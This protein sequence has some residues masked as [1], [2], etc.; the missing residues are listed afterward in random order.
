MAHNDNEDKRI[1]A[2][3]HGDQQ[4]RQRKD[5]VSRLLQLR[6]SVS[7]IQANGQS[8][9]KNI[10]PIMRFDFE[11]HLPSGH[12]ERLTEERRALLIAARKNGASRLQCEL[13]GASMNHVEAPNSYRH[14]ALTDSEIADL[15]RQLRRLFEVGEL[16][17]RHEGLEFA[18]Q[19]K[20]RA[21][22]QASKN[23]NSGVKLSLEQAALIG[24]AE[25]YKLAARLFTLSRQQ[26]N[27]LFTLEERLR[28][29]WQAL[30]MTA[31]PQDISQGVYHT[32]NVAV[33][34]NRLFTVKPSLAAKLIVDVATTG[35]YRTADGSDIVMTAAMLRQDDQAM[36]PA[37]DGFRNL[38]GMIFQR[39]AV[40]IYW[41][42][43]LRRPDNLVVPKGSIIFHQFD[44][45]Q[46]GDTGERLLDLSKNPP[47]ELINEKWSK[48]NPNLGLARIVEVYAQINLGLAPR[49]LILAASCFDHC[50]RVLKIRS[51]FELTKLF[52]GIKDACE[53]PVFVSVPK[54]IFVVRDYDEASDAVA[55][56]NSWS[57]RD[58]YL[59]A[60]AGSRP[61]LKVEELYAQM[62]GAIEHQSRS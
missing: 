8:I 11:R 55:V 59:G 4:S 61:R 2:E 50:G 43:Q 58:D 17:E 19:T 24:T 45:R 46:D 10:N 33:I 47:Q 29:A 5:F 49:N 34:Q 22:E 35:H 7:F 52:K 40:N 38:A 18:H 56:D 9:S 6:E 23:W 41:Q 21:I 36:K 14:P 60:E 27:C 20:Q 32:C 16:P 25:L 3:G 12:T 54:H 42:R 48:N 39:T 13:L 62:T 53:F 28:I 51:A 31:R 44:P 37:R 15:Y 57:S 30:D 1:E 26:K